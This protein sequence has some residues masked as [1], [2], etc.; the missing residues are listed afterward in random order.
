VGVGGTRLSRL[1]EW[2]PDAIAH[3]RKALGGRGG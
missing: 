1:D 3:C 2:L